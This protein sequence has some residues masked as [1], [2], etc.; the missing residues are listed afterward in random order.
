MPKLASKKYKTAALQLCV[1]VTAICDDLCKFAKVK[2][3]DDETRMYEISWETL[4][5]ILGGL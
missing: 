5:K 2:A 4:H 3:A 1:C